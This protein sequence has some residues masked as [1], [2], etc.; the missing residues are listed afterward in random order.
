MRAWKHLNSSVNTFDY[1]VLEGRGTEIKPVNVEV[2]TRICIYGRKTFFATLTRL[3]NYKGTV[4]TSQEMQ[5]FI[6]K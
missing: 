4:I 6:I 1:L 2:T 5:N 3:Y